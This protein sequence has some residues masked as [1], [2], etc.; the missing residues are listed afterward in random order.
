M[1]VEVIGAVAVMM[2]VVGMA[3]RLGRS[4]FSCCCRVL[5]QVG[6]SAPA[7]HCLGLFE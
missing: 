3:C 6:R 7:V 5:L 2:V 1:E 4:L